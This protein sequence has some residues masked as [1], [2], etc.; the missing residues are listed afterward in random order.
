MTMAFG[1]GPSACHQRRHRY[2]RR[3]H[4][5][6]RSGPGGHVTRAFGSRR[7]RERVLT[8]AGASE[9]C[10]N[11]T[12]VPGSRRRKRNLRSKTV[13]YRSTLG[14]PYHHVAATDL[15]RSEP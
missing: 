5:T 11:G 1:T 12:Q 13:Y 14:Y 4:L 9:Y 2:H 15:Y 6:A 3:V 8:T 7:A 10:A